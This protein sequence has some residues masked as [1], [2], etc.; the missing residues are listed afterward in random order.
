MHIG[1]GDRL[2]YQSF[3]HISDLHDLDLGSGHLA[4]RHV[5]LID[6]YLL[7]LPR[8]LEYYSSHFFTTRVLVNF[9]FR[10]QI[11]KL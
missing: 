8:V 11:S 5:S 4:Y 6:L 3:S 7:G 9:Y 1:G 10:L 2:R